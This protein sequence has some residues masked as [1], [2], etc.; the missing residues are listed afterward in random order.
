MEDINRLNNNE[1]LETY[2]NGIVQRLRYTSLLKLAIF[3]Q[4]FHAAFH[5]PCQGLIE[6]LSQGREGNAS[7]LRMMF[8]TYQGVLGREVQFN[9]FRRSFER[10]LYLI[11]VWYTEDVER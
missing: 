4:S 8:N 1:M 5:L 9:S 3:D 10:L 11:P 7:A 2:V 6:F